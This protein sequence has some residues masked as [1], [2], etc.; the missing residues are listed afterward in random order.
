MEKKL[1]FSIQFTK[2]KKLIRIMKCCLIFIILGIGSCFANKSYS[3]ELFFNFE[4]TNQT[5]R[6]VIQEIEQNSD[7][8]FF[9]LDNSVDLDR[10]VSVSAENEGIE[11]VLDQLF[12]GTQNHYAISDRQIII[13]SGKTAGASN[14]APAQQP[15]ERTITGVVRDAAGPIIGA[16]VI[17]KGTT[18]G[19]ATDANGQ[20]TLSNIQPNAVLQ[21]KY[22]G[23]KPQEVNV[24]NQTHFDITIQEENQLVNEVVVVGFGTQKKVNLT[25]SVGIASAADLDS[26]PVMNATQALEGIVPGLNISQNMGMLDN[27]P[28]INVRG[29]G[30]LTWDGNGNPSVA[31]GAP[32]IL[33]DGMENDINTI[34]PQDIESVSVL[35]DAAA[36]SIYGSRA[37]FGVI[38]ITT[39]SGKAGKPVF[40]YNNSFRWNS[41]V[42]LP[43]MVD[44]YTFATYFNDAAFNQGQAARFS[45]DQMQRIKDYQAGTLKASVPANPDNG[46]WMDG[47]Y[48]GNDNV[49]WYRAL[50]RNQVFS[51]NHDLSVSG[52]NESANYY[53]SAGYM[54]MN[55]LMRFNPDTYQRYNLTSKIGL[56]FAD[57]AKLNYNVRFIRDDYKKPAYLYSNEFE[58]IGSQAWPTLPLYDPNGYLYASPSP[59]LNLSEG[60]NATSQIDQLTQQAQFVL[61]PVTHWKTYLELNYKTVNNDSHSDSQQLI[62]HDVNGDPYPYWAGSSVGESYTKNNF[63]NLNI[64]SEYAKSLK[65]GH[66][67]K[68]MAGFQAELFKQTYFGAS[69]SGIMVPGLPN[70]DLTTGMDAQGNVQSP[71]VGGNNDHWSTAGFFGRLNYDFQGK[72]LAEVNLRYDG[73]SRFRSDNRWGFFPSFSVGWNIAEENFWSSLT[74][75]VGMLKI[76]AS[77]GELGNQNTTGF[78]PTYQIL[79]M[80]ISS[81]DWLINGKRPNTA[82]APTLISSTLTWERVQV[83]N[84]GLDFSALKNRL[85]GSF[86]YYNRYTFDMVGPAPQLPVTLGTAVPRTNNT[87]L[88]TYGFELVLQ[89][90]D[91]LANGFRYSAKFSLADSRTEV[92][93]FPNITGALDTYREGQIVGEIWGYTTKGIAQTQ[94][95]MDNH[96]AGLP[97]G[98][99]NALG[100]LWQAGDIM[101]VDANG[102][103]KIDG[104]AGTI[105]DHGDLSIIGNSTPRYLF[106]LDLNAGYKGFDFRAFFQGVMKRDY[107]CDQFFFWGAYNTWQSNCFYPNLDYFRDD[108]NHVLGENLNAYFPRPMFDNN[109]NK[110]VQTRYLQNAAYIRLKNIQ[111]GYTLPE[112]WLHHTFMSKIRLFVSGENMWTGT[113]MFKTFDPETVDGGWNGNVY[114]LCSTLSFGLNINF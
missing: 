78:Y 35:K 63:M 5:V 106:G 24:G 44:S 29:L 88:K 113:K 66:N 26:R 37:P 92:T 58:L 59:A 101:Y 1:K 62:N 17:V 39:K 56:K 97:N 20:F 38:L 34:N 108:P 71:G 57:W 9:Y 104:G 111:L 75:Y 90:N 33:I 98:G 73:S 40:N 12:A 87:D 53:V 55:G 11:K 69:R 30:T 51:Q 21:V 49:D 48:Y 67:F 102:D 91:R 81:G 36:S 54:D 84:I 70:L 28:S 41:P 27:T 46:K 110:Q 77:Y 14:A 82:A 43:Q 114:P 74:S 65:S 10:K 2:Q 105:K 13:S 94:Q 18:T 100:S 89:W 107:W 6:E 112:S 109:K 68:G 22:I 95:E 103:G 16:S 76:R 50:F 93:R 3:Q 52:G 80:G 60:G 42:L 86:D 8:L 25:G 85:T 61:E 72:Y 83:R 96:L 32:L 64:Y 15:Q 99:Q 19:V 23:Y 47:Y 45:P 4:Y 31:A 7:Y 79:S